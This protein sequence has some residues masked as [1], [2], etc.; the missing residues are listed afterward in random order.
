MSV[1]LVMVQQEA[2]L[3]ARRAARSA[4]DLRPFRL[5]APMGMEWVPS[6]EY[7]QAMALVY[8]FF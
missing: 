1:T 6:P 4:A 2:E 3:E 8:M 7:L 5:K